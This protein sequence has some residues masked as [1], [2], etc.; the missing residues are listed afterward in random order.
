[1]LI[2]ASFKSIFVKE[3][4][5]IYKRILGLIPIGKIIDISKCLESFL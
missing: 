1:M 2:T 4:P 3:I 5:V